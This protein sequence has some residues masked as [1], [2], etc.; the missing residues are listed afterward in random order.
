MQTLNM[1]FKRAET[2]YRAIM[3][4]EDISVNILENYDKIM[5][6]DS[7]IFR[8]IKIQD[9][10]GD[11]LFKNLLKAIEEYKE[12]MSV[13]DILDKLE[14]LSIIDDANQ[15]VEFRKI[16]NILTHEYPFNEE[17]M[18]NGLKSGLTA[19]IDIKN[20][21]FKIIKYIEKKKLIKNS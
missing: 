10:M 20:I 2:A 4:W 17:E 19:F 9:L 3:S 6:V 18:I 8:L 16:R 15:W 21:Y 13:L 5:V 11:K 14:K 12:E 1:H 7:F